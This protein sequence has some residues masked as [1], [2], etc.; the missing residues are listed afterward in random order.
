[1]YETKDVY[2]NREEPVQVQTARGNVSARV[3]A[4]TPAGER[5]ASARADYNQEFKGST[6]IPVEASSEESLE[7]YLMDAVADRAA[8]TV[9]TTQA[10]VEALLAVDGDLKD[11]NKLAEAGLFQEALAAWSRKPLKGDKEAARLHNIGVAHEAMAYKLLPES[12]EHLASLQRAAESYE[13]ARA[14]DPGEKYFAEPNQR[15]Q[16]SIGYANTAT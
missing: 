3:E 2:G 1:K 15:I 7:R 9:V 13:K 4:T 8:A 10:P 12:P 6:R 5:S 16:E 14:L 11:G